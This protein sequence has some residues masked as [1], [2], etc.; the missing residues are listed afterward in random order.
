MSGASAAVPVGLAP[1]CERCSRSPLAVVAGPL[2]VGLDDGGTRDTDIDHVVLVGRDPCRDP[3]AAAELAAAIT[4]R[5][6]S[7][8]ITTSSARTVVS[9]LDTERRRRGQRLA[10]L[11]VVAHAADRS[12]AAA[13]SLAVLDLVAAARRAAESAATLACSLAAVAHRVLGAPTTSG[14]AAAAVVAA[15]SRAIAVDADRLAAVDQQQLIVVVI[16]VVPII[17]ARSNRIIVAVLG[18]AVPYGV[19]VLD[20][21]VL[22]LV[23]A[24]VAADLAVSS[25]TTAAPRA[26]AIAA[27]RRRLGHPP[28]VGLQHQHAVRRSGCRLDLAA[29]LAAVRA[30]AV[31]HRLCGRVRHRHRHRLGLGRSRP[32]AVVDL[33]SRR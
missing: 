28:R 22:S 6:N 16:V 29:D 10:R 13:P 11:A 7:S 23:A 25:T 2:S 14:V 27:G 5:P 8:T 1:I 32:A 30:R 4:A 18:C 33:V 31:A 20:L 3:R 19:G 21:G 17:A 15:T 26:I 9:G 12:A 24:A